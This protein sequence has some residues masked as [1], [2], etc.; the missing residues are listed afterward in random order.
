[1]KIIL[2]IFVSVVFVFGASSWSW[3][4]ETIT[5]ELV[6]LDCYTK[7]KVKNVGVTHQDCATMCAM[8]GQAV[9]VV[10]DKGEV[11]TIAGELTDGHN[12][13]LA[14]HMSHRVVLTGE[15]SEKDGHKV[16]HA[17]SLKMAGP[18]FGK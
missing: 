3:A 8:K 6:D 5:G 13:L 11:F 4:A 7:D 10:T 18:R 14:P 2:R 12:A 17:T 16:I 15:V 1:M 9:A